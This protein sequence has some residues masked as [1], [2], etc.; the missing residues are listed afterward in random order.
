MSVSLGPDDQ[1]IGHRQLLFRNDNYVPGAR[2]LDARQDTGTV[3]FRLI[4]RILRKGMNSRP[5]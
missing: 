3:V 1:I 2:Q 4:A 5:V